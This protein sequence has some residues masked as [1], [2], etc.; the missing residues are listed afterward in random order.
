MKNL[1]VNNDIAKKLKEKMFDE[2]CLAYYSGSDLEDKTIYTFTT[3]SIGSSIH[4]NSIEGFDKSYTFSAPLYD[5]VVSWLESK[6]IFFDSLH[7]TQ[8]YYEYSVFINVGECIDG[9]ISSRIGRKVFVCCEKTRTLAL[10]SCIEE[11]LKFI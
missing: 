9:R 3:F 6:N 5:Q 4:R 11:A 10:K 8:K 2:P 1:F 7:T